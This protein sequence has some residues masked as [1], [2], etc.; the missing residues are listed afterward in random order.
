MFR[1]Y[2]KIAWRNIKRHPTFSVINIAGLAIGL[3]ACIIIGLWV[4]QQL[5]FDRFN[6]K[7]GRIYRLVYHMTYPGGSATINAL[8]V[9][10]ANVLNHNYT[11]IKKAVR[12]STQQLSSMKV[13]KTKKQLFDQKGYMIA[14][15]V[16][17]KMF[18]FPVLQGNPH[19]LLQK[20]GSVVMTEKA[21]QKYFSDRQAVGQTLKVNGKLKTVTGVV[22]DP[23]PN[24]SLQFFMVETSRGNEQSTRKRWEPNMVGIYVLL[25]S[26]TGIQHLQSS[27]SRLLGKRQGTWHKKGY[28]DSVF[29]QP[30]TD[31]HLGRGIPYHSHSKMNAT[32]VWLFAALALFILLLASINYIN[33]ATARS[34]ER[35]CEVG[36]RKTLGA[37]RWGLAGQFLG[38]AAVTCLLSLL[39][40][41][42]IV[43]LIMPVFN[44]AIGSHLS[45]AQLG[46]W[47]PVLI[48]IGLLL[49]LI[50]FSSWY[51]ALL[52]SGFSPRS[53]FESEQS[54]A[55]SQRTRKGLVIFQFAIGVI[56]IIATI[57][58]YR[59]LNYMR[60]ASLGFNKDQVIT[61]K[62][63]N[64]AVSLNSNQEK[65]IMEVKTR[66]HT[67]KNQLQKQ[68]YVK[69]ASLAYS[70]PSGF[71]IS[72]VWHGVGANRSKK[73]EVHYTF[74]DA[75]YLRTL[76]IKLAAGRN[77]SNHRNDS[78]STIINE[79]TANIFFGANRKAIDKQIYWQ[80]R[81]LKVVGV[82][83]N[84]HYKSLRHQVKPMAL[85]Y[86]NG[87]EGVQDMAVKLK[88]GHIQQALAQ[89][90]RT[91]QKLVP[92][93]PFNYSFLDQ[94][95]ASQYKTEQQTGRV[96]TG[97]TIL[98]IIVACLGLFG[99]TTYAVQRRTKEIGIRKVLGASEASIVGLL[100]KD[101]LKLVAIGFVIAVPIGWY[102][103][104]RW[105][106]NFAY[107][108]NMSWWIFLLA[109]GIAL[110]I[111]LA[112]V[113][114][115]SVKAA[116][117]NPV[118]SLRSE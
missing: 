14:D 80:G 9:P 51:P 99:L 116:L 63:L 31:I 8:P 94:K 54:G 32:Y 20:P 107:K 39:I 16:F 98:A 73:N 46:G 5:S 35:A 97:F 113:S 103:M 52:L 22:A 15:P 108:I 25:H 43:Q 106:Q 57:V 93:V 71:F 28:S 3:A 70:V 19:Q 96:F 59:Q 29:L 48:L 101:F 23:P 60:T 21:A 55:G 11:D 111:A 81:H 105:L 68:P 42:V 114:W 85:I 65:T 69:N 75:N 44:H 89:V 37:N 40:A 88:A 17:F 67:L 66:F 24:S 33:L 6:K 7:S 53:V 50:L 87:Y 41:L 77:F 2:L 90:K 72:E 82:V 26:S 74:V 45:L 104:H 83:K 95:V 58:V 36:I 1:N 30:L 84:F 115:Q 34:A 38:E 117:A 112:T 18:T 62:N 91:W 10:L 92:N 47:I 13:I 56:L 27:I 79:K 102:A 4:Q 64:K 86:N 109:G 118:D 110:I 76:G 61:V 49:F 12:V 78:L 100:S